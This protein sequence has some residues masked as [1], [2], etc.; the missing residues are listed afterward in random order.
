MASFAPGALLGRWVHSREEDTADGMVYRPASYSFPAARGR[1]GFDLRDDGTLLAARP[2]PVDRTI[3]AAG[4]WTLE[5]DGLLAL[6]STGPGF[7]A[8]RLRVVSVDGERLVVKPE[9][10]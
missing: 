6:S 1:E 4:T 9:G 3:E 5:G 7:P 2:G 10:D 8:K